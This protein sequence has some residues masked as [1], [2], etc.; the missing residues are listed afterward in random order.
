MITSDTSF[1]ESSTKVKAISIL[2]IKMSLK[3]VILSS[4]RIGTSELNI[5]CIKKTSYKIG[6]LLK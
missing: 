4:I 6:I 3:T 2:A 5:I 1:P